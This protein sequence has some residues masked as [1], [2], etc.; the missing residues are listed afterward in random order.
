MHR[1]HGHNLF[2]KYL[3]TNYN[4]FNSKNIIEIGTT[5][6]KYANQS[7]TIKIAKVCN[8]FGLNF[9]TVNMDPKNSA[10]AE[11]DLLLVNPSFKAV[12]S[13]GE[14]YL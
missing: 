4:N 5:R 2:I 12:V 13:K 6:E 7:S 9:T 11:K 8:R 3:M 10:V 14:D 1:I